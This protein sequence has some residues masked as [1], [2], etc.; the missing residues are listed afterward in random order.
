MVST[1]LDLV[2]LSRSHY[3]MACVLP[4]QPEPVPSTADIEA[5]KGTG[6]S[7]PPPCTK[8]RGGTPNPP[9]IDGLVFLKISF[10]GGL[11]SEL[12]TQALISDA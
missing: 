3:G 5:F 4:S 7:R 12:H 10:F 11:S 1:S 8:F 6:I 9:M 2:Y